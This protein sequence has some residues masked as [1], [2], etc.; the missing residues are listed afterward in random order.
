MLSNRNT[1]S[2]AS[3]VLWTLKDLYKERAKIVGLP[4]SAD[5]NFA[6]V[7]VSVW[8]RKPGES[9]YPIS[10]R[11]F[12]RPPEGGEPIFSEAI[13]IG[14]TVDAKGTVLAGK[15]IVPDI[16]VPIRTFDLDEWHKTVLIRAMNIFKSL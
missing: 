13:A 2:S 10:I 14:Q 7:L 1:I 9:N 12:G 8:N 4:D 15:P 5:T 11:P 3:E 16:L 6:R